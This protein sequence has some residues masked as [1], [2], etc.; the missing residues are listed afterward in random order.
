ME[1]SMGQFEV[2][3][4][5]ALEAVRF[6]KGK[7]K[8]GAKNKVKDLIKS[9]GESLDCVDTLRGLASTREAEILTNYADNAHAGAEREAELNAMLAAKLGCGNCNEQAS[10]AFIYLRDKGVFPIDL[11]NKENDFLNYGGHSFVVIGRID[12]MIKPADWGGDAVICDPHGS[13]T[14]FPASQFE[15][16][17]PRAKLF[18]KLRLGCRSDSTIKVW[19]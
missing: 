10:L 7:M 8:Y 17:M 9:R 16:Y 3:L 11:I 15:Q 14:A 6:V 18:G 1:E 2:N 5:A 4:A 13:E 12:K 19:H